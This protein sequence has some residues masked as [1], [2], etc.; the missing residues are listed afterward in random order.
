M[1]D[2]RQAEAGERAS[3]ERVQNL[4]RELAGVIN[5]SKAERREELRESVIHLLRDEV[6][7]SEA[8]APTAQSRGAFNSFGIGIPMFLA[9][10]VLIVLFP[11]VGLLLILGAAAAM[12]WG[13]V[14]SLLSRRR[15]PVVR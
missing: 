4:A 10:G 2:E 13:V 15:D 11:P 1:I 8:A 9:G 3:D 14:A 7:D 5:A 6:Q 12:A